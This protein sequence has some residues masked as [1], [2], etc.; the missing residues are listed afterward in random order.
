MSNLSTKGREI[1][2][3]TPVAYPFKFERPT[4]IHVRIRT[5]II[6]ALSDMRHSQEFDT[7]EEADD[8]R[9]EDDPDMWKSPYEQD[10]DHLGVYDNKSESSKEESAEGDSSGGDSQKEDN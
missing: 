5:Q 9:M 8:F 6:Q 7:P 2:D 1:F 4:P 10:F 3:Q